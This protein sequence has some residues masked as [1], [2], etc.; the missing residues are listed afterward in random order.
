VHPLAIVSLV[1]GILSIPLCCCSFMG[2]W[3]PIGAIVCGVIAMNKIKLEPGAFTGN[4]LAI[5]G[6]ATGAVG[7]LLDLVAIFSTFDDVLKSRYGHF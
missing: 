3:A 4:G 6:I 5:A 2:S 7:F 1:L